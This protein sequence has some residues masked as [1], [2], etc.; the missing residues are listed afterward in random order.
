MTDKEIKKIKV[1]W[2]KQMKYTT[3]VRNVP[4]ITYSRSGGC[5]SCSGGCGGGSEGTKAKNPADLTDTELAEFE[6]KLKAR[7]DCEEPCDDCSCKPKCECGASA[8][9]GA[10]HTDYCPLYKK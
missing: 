3:K 6:R 2:E 8:V 5:S 4:V 7:C 9:G 1:E 10:F